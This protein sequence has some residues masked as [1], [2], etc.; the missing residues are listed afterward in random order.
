MKIIYDCIKYVVDY[1][2]YYFNV[3]YL[4]FVVLLYFVQFYSNRDIMIKERID[5]SGVV[6]DF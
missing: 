5:V 2:I 6:L 4:Y 3:V 1:L